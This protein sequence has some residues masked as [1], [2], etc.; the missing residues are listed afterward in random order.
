MGVCAAVFIVYPS[1]ISAILLSIC[2]FANYMGAMADAR[3]DE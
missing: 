3:R 1:L 2:I